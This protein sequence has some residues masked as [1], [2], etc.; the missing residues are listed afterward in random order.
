MH[1]PPPVLRLLERK[2]LRGGFC[3]VLLVLVA[4]HKFTEQ[5]LV[6]CLLDC[7]SPEGDERGG[8]AA[9]G[10]EG[11]RTYPESDAAAQREAQEGG[12]PL[13][14]RPRAQVRETHVVPSECSTVRLRPVG[15]IMILHMRTLASSPKFIY[16]TVLHHGYRTGVVDGQGIPALA[17]CVDTVCG[18]YQESYQWRTAL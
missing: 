11:G 16:S 13:A 14:P 7:A 15:K 3:L 5:A 18:G 10:G 2:T 9:R 12:A 8:E 17:K 4:K 6:L 1:A